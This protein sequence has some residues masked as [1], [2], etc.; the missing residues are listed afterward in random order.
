MGKVPSQRC[1]FKVIKEHHHL[2]FDGMVFMAYVAEFEAQG[3]TCFV[4]R[5]E[6]S[7][8]LPI[9][10]SGVRYLIK[11]L[12][13]EGYLELQYE[14]NKSGTRWIR[15][16]KTTMKSRT[17]NPGIGANSAPSGGTINPGVGANSAPEGGHEKATTKKHYKETYIKKHDKEI[18]AYN[19]K[20]L[21]VN[22]E[23]QPDFEKI[24]HYCEKIGLKK[25]FV[26]K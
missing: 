9:S 23:P 16:V 26:E 3:K 17:D 19:S 2:G 20:V 18:Y 4:S 6:I 13:K 11:R 12:V 14:K 21:N 15:H 7:K 5:A 22:L 1:F 8:V 10:E 24:N 25:R